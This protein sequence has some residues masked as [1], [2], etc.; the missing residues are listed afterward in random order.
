MANEAFQ[1]LIGGEAL[2]AE[3]R[4]DALQRASM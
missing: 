3:M 4:F 2:N 1:F